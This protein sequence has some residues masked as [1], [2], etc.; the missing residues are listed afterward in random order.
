MTIVGKGAALWAGSGTFRLP[1]E[2]L[3]VGSDLMSRPLN[4]NVDAMGA[5]HP[6]RACP[7]A[8]ITDGRCL[9]Q[10]EE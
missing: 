6:P 3:F 5:N 2:Y 7:E 8:A 4:P 10:K 1:P 9:L